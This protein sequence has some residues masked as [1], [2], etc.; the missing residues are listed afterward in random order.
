MVQDV[1]TK[2]V[3]RVSLQHYVWENSAV[4]WSL[5]ILIIHSVNMGV[6][7]MVACRYSYVWPAATMR[8]GMAGACRSQTVRHISWRGSAP[9]NV[10]W[11]KM[12]SISDNVMGFAGAS[13]HHQ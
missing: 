4:F 10:T 13:Q 8:L 9:L 11:K 7:Q 3:S 6:K 5:I 2:S 12:Y 1:R